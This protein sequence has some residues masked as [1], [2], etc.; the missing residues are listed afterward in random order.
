MSKSCA[1]PGIMIKQLKNIEK[2]AMIPAL[3]AGAAVS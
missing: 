1:N 2:G 3:S